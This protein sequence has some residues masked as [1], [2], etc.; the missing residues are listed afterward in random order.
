MPIYAEA[1]PPPEPDTPVA[2]IVTIAAGALFGLSMLLLLRRYWGLD[3]D[4]ALYLGQALLQRWPEIYAADLFFANGSQG[5]YTLFPWLLAQALDRADPAQLFLFGGLAGLVFFAAASWS[6]LR[7]LLPESQRYWAWLGVLCLPT[8]YGT[9][10]IFGYA[11]SFLTPRT[12]A[13]PLCLLGIGLL[14][15]R[16]RVAAAACAAAAGILHPLQTIAALLVVWPWLVMRDRRW[17]H[18]A[19]LSLPVALV[20]ALGVKPFDGLFRVIDAEWMS[21][22]LRFNGQLFVSRLRPFD[23]KTLVLDT[24]LLA[25]AWRT[26]RGAFATWCGAALAGLWLGV[27]SSLL[28]V[29]ALHLELPAAL[30]LW[31]THWLAHWFAMAAV[32]ALLYRDVR[33]GDTPRALL[34]ALVLVL[35]WGTSAWMWLPAAALYAAWPRVSNRVRPHVRRLLGA[36]FLLIMLVLLANHVMMELVTFERVAHRLDLYAIDRRLL[37]FPLVALGLPLLATHAWTRIGQRGRVLLLALAVVPLCVVSL[38]RWDVRHPTTRALESRAFQSDLFGVE[39]PRDAQVF[40]DGVSLVGPWLTLQRADYFSPQ[41]VSGVIFNRG[42]SRDV[43]A[44]IE[45]VGLLLQQSLFCRERSRTQD[46]LDACHVN[47]AAMRLACAPGPIPG[48]DYIV[49]MLRQPQRA[50][51]VWTIADPLDGSPLATYYLYRCSDV[52]ADLPRAEAGEAG[53]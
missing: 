44:R 14:A 6:C 21:E 1:S 37:V 39:I 19:W 12:F 45:R 11:E 36:L 18:A 2:R 7:A 49:L 26:M 38:W 8:L 50:A 47:D 51:G 40:W 17:L 53:K 9:T 20:A 28:L 24:F 33:D 41:Q 31:R 35:S 48:P 15:R 27:L 43:M 3:H 34:L 52:M 16:H 23:Y 25:M 10:I 46:E 32:A 13:E 22:L 4:A 29:D 30:Q 42:T 5:R